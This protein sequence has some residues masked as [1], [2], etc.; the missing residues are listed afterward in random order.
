MS[1][2]LRFSLHRVLKAGC[3]ED[4]TFF[5][6]LGITSVRS[7]KELRTGISVYSISGLPYP[8]AEGLY[9]FVPRIEG[10]ALDRVI[11]KHLL[12]SSLLGQ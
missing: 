7:L 11:T 8:S 9:L 5:G 2:R 1:D 4:H 6:I 10:F 12:H 3:E